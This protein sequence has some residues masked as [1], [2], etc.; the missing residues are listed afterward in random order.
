MSK[1][2]HPLFAALL[3][4]LAGCQDAG[5]QGRDRVWELRRD[6]V[7]VIDAAAPAKLVAL[8]GWQSAAEP[9]ACP[10]ALALGPEGEAVVTSNV[11]PILWR[12]DAK[13][14]AVSVH[15]LALDADADKD[16][17]FSALAWSSADAAF[18]GVSNA[19]GSLWKIDAN[20]GK[21]KKLAGLAPSREQPCPDVAMQMSRVFLDQ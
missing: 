7:L 14:L 8:P 4:S 18:L 3:F 11:L 16:V 9:Y 1:S 2:M 10:S 12:I 15:S 20:L 6:G 21:G 17:G 19:D 5:P 13:T